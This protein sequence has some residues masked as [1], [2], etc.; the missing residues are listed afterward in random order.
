MPPF[1]DDINT[2]TFLMGVKDREIWCLLQ[3]QMQVMKTIAEPPSRK[4]LAEMI[5]EFLINHREQ[6]ETEL[7]PHLE[8][9][10]KH[11]IRAP[12]SFWWMQ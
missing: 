4:Q 11:L 8:K 10:C 2:A 1:K 6:G 5:Y 7:S 12:P 3:S 9:F